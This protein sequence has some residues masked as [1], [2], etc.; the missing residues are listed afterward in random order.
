M[1]IVSIE[2]LK[3]NLKNM[4]VCCLLTQNFQTVLIG[5]WEIIFFCS[6]LKKHTL[7]LGKTVID[8]SKKLLFFF[9]KEI[10]AK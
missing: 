9:A 7:F 5:R 10:N 3:A 6:L 2:Y 8:T 1:F 4:F